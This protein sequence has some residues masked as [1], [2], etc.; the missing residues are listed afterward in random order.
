MLLILVL[1]LLVLPVWPVALA[2]AAIHAARLALWAPLATRGRPILWI[3]P[4]LPY[5][6]AWC[7]WHCAAA[8][9]DLVP[10]ALATHALTVG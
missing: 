6:M 4:V 8:G 1:D 2:A 9:L 5:W 3:L 10:A 7:T